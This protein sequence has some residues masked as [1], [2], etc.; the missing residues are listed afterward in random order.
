MK[1]DDYHQNVNLIE[2]MR[3]V[4]QHQGAGD[5][6]V[7]AGET[8]TRESDGGTRV[9]LSDTSREV[10]KAREAMETQ[11]P[12]RA[13]RVAELKNRIAEGTYEVDSQKVA[14]RILGTAISD[15]L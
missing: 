12:E 15:L 6:G 14:E 1:I 7:Q 8:D 9:A 5:R 11:D 2:N 13:A 3:E 10:M 4:G